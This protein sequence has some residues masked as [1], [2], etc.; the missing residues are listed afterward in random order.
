MSYIHQIGSSNPQVYVITT[1]NPLSSDLAITQHPESFEILTGTPPVG[2]VGLYYNPDPIPT[3]TA[4]PLKNPDGSTATNLGVAGTAAFTTAPLAANASWNTGWIAYG[5][6]QS[7]QYVLFTDQVSA[8][9]GFVFEYS[10]D[11]GA[12]V[13]A[14]ATVLVT[15]NVVNDFRFSIFPIGKGTHIRITYTNGATPQTS[16]FFSLRMQVDLSCTMT[17]IFS[18]IGASAIAQ[19]TKTFLNIPDTNVSATALFDMITRTGNSLNVNMTNTPAVSGTVS[20]NNFPASTEIAND[21]GS[22]I[23]INGTVTANAGTNLNTS[24]LALDSTVAKDA[25]LTT[26]NTSVNNLLKPASTLTKVTTVDTITNPIAVN[27]FPVT[28][29]ISATTLPLPTGASTETTL[30]L[31]KT[32]LGAISDSQSTN[33]TASWSVASLLKGL[34][35]QIAAINTDQGNTTDAAATDGSTT[36]WGEIALLKGIITQLLSINS[37]QGTISDAQATNSSASWGEIALLKGI[38]NRPA[39]GAGTSIA[40]STT[41]FTILAANANRKG[42]S[43]FQ[44][45]SGNLFI[46]LGNGV[47]LTNYTARVITNALYE[48]PFGYTGIITGI[49]STTN[50]SVRITELT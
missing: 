4:L 41:S 21:S 45:G 11:G 2:S 6:Y 16:F 14:P 19:L 42:A 23:P 8:A 30:L 39:T 7:G 46:F 43:I 35:T 24:A 12:T 28:Q 17:S 9:N 44:E 25:S 36:S 33:G 20:V 31:I 15:N 47:S 13:F 32:V 27:N 34:Y 48:I 10:A 3:L 49:S 5:Q 29:P 40:N 26:L 38:L 37:D 22:P 1:S 50:G 18:N